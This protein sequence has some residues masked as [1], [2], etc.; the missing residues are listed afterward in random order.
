MTAF[1]TSDDILR[2]IQ[3]TDGNCGRACAQM[4]IAAL[5]LA[6]ASG[7]NPAIINVLPTQ[8]ILAPG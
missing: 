3:D 6:P 4:M 1:S 5:T 7:A 8:A 2:H